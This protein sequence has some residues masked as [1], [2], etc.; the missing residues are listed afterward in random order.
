MKGTVFHHAAAG[1]Y[2]AGA[3]IVSALALIRRHHSSRARSAVQSLRFVSA[4]SGSIADGRGS[5]YRR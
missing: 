4:G 3:G 2:R 5:G 1:R